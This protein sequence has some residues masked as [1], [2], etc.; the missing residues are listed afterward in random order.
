MKRWKPQPSKVRPERPQPR[1]LILP[2]NLQESRSQEP[3]HSAATTKLLKRSEWGSASQHTTRGGMNDPSQS[4]SE[5][6]KSLTLRLCLR[7]TGRKSV[8]EAWSGS[9]PE[10]RVVE[11]AR[12]SSKEK[13]PLLR[14]ASGKPYPYSFSSGCPSNSGHRLL[15]LLKSVPRVR[16]S[17]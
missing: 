4:A 2:V 9:C 3:C 14:I 10:P 5:H 12:V 7:Y 1:P 16:S 13:G 15:L 17:G 11:V 6:T 8:W